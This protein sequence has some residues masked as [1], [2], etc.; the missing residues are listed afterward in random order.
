[1]YLFGYTLSSGLFLTKFL[2]ILV[3]FFPGASRL[4]CHRSS[5]GSPQLIVIILS[6]H[7]HH[8]VFEASCDRPICPFQTVIDVTINVKCRSVVSDDVFA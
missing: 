7:I 3:G 5:F 8:Y 4:C 6:M 1:M 2:E